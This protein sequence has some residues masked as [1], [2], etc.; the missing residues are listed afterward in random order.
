[1]PE[2]VSVATPVLVSVAVCV[3]VTSAN[4]RVAGV[5][6]TAGP[7][8]VGGVGG[9]VVVV[10]GVVGVP[11]PPH[12]TPA[13]TSARRKLHR[14]AL[15]DRLETCVSTEVLGSEAGAPCRLDETT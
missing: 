14:H 7:V 10:D 5:N 4:A 13:T 2:I 9:V 11:D 8:G 3:A 12:A 15:I 6:V 1:M